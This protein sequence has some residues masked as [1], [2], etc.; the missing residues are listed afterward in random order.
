MNALWL[1]I[2]L[3]VL[4]LLL[5]L[6]W[7]KPEKCEFEEKCEFAGIWGCSPNTCQVRQVFIVR[8]L[9]QAQQKKKEEEK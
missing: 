2:P 6:I 7:C 1:V 4:S 3:L 9:L 5:L 8:D